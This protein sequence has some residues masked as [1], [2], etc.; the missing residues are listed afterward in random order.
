MD[1]KKVIIVIGGLAAVGTA[2]YF[3]FRKRP[4]T[5]VGAI[6]DKVSQT[7]TGEEL[8]DQPSGSSGGKTIPSGD[9]ITSHTTNPIITPSAGCSSY[10]TE[11]WPLAKCMKGSKVKELQTMLN[12]T[13]GSKLNTSVKADGYFGP[14]TENFVHAVLGSRV[15]KESDF[16][17]IKKAYQAVSNME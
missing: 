12:K 13:Y 3:I 10:K 17:F 14:A 11:S 16:N 9:I 1:K 6:I 15:C 4:D 5:A 8:S 2:L 7:F